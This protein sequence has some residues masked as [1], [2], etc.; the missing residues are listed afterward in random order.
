MMFPYSQVININ[1]QHCGPAI[2]IPYHRKTMESFDL[3]VKQLSGPF[4]NYPESK[5]ESRFFH[6]SITLEPCFQTSHAELQYVKQIL[7]KSHFG[8]KG[9]RGSWPPCGLPPPPSISGQITGPQGPREP[10]FEKQPVQTS[11]QMAAS[12][13]L[14][15]PPVSPRAKLTQQPALFSPNASRDQ[16]GFGLTLLYIPEVVLQ[17]QSPI[18]NCLVIHVQFIFLFHKS[19]V[20]KKCPQHPGCL[21]LGINM[22]LRLT[23]YQLWKTQNKH[24]HPRERPQLRKSLLVEQ[25]WEGVRERSVRLVGRSPQTLLPSSAGWPLPVRD[26]GTLLSCAFYRSKRQ[27]KCYVFPKTQKLPLISSP[28]QTEIIPNL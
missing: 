6:L 28:S 10:Q 24:P 11:N 16:V 23:V 7:K 22:T 17:S 19:S 18:L 13:P 9:L 8:C 4:C 5:F 26:P 2:T 20:F 12:S 25:D 14:S 27:A 3:T 1:I 21:D 15:S